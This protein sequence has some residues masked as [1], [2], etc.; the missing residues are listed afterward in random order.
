MTLEIVTESEVDEKPAGKGR[1]EPNMNP[2][3]DPPNRP[4]TSFFWFTNPCKTMK[5]IVW[6]RFKWIFIGIIILL[7]VLLF[8]GILLYSLPNYISMKIVKPFK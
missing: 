6:R 5:F 2:K 4:D 1:D 7:L 3:L 8:F